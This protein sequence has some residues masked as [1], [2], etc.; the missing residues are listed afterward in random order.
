MQHFQNTALNSVIRRV[1]SNIRESYL[2][3]FLFSPQAQFLNNFFSTQKR[4]NRDKIDFAAIQCDVIHFVALKAIFFF[5]VCSIKPDIFFR[6]SV[7]FQFVQFSGFVK[8]VEFSLRNWGWNLAKLWSC[9][10]IWAYGALHWRG[11]LNSLLADFLF[12]IVGALK[13][14]DHTISYNCEQQIMTLTWQ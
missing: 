11:N 4:V 2:I 7:V 14:L 5:G 12:S 3:F 10:C 1:S 8:V 6:F 9:C 13:V